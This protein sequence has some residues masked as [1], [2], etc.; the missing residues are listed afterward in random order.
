MIEVF[1][2]ILGTMWFIGCFGLPLYGVLTLWNDGENG[3]ALALL[4]IGWP[5]GVFMGALP[6][7]FY[8]DAQ[9]PHLSLNKTEWVCTSRHSQTT[10]TFVMSGKVMIPITSTRQVCDQYTH[11]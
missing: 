7:A 1:L 11:R 10:T 4:L 5:I 3:M 9:D 6:W 8:A 2:T